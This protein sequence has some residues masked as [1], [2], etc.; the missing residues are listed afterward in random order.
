V[1]SSDELTLRLQKYLGV[2]REIVF[3][4]CIEPQ[5]LAEWW[6]PK[7]FSSSSVELDPQPGGMY[8]IGMQPPEGEL[9]Y[10]RGTFREVDSPNRLVYTFEWEDPDPDD[11][12][13]VVTLAFL[14]TG[15]GTLLSLEQ[16]PFATE[17]RY[18]LHRAGWTDALERLEESLVRQ[19]SV[20]V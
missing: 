16:G 7:G 2:P 11:R 13:N 17:A 12:E 9:F 20:R 14:E 3:A 8:R 5:R 10:L 4:A 19:A 18:E 15:G 6:G 1:T